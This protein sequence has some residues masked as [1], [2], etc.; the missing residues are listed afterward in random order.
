MRRESHSSTSVIV[1][2]VRVATLTLHTMNIVTVSQNTQ[3]VNHEQFFRDMK[4]R[5]SEIDSSFYF[6]VS[7]KK[8]II[9]NNSS[10]LKYKI[11]YSHF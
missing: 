9:G 1:Y 5:S 7:L 2:S 4:K 6:K 10:L 11:Y 8:S 3:A